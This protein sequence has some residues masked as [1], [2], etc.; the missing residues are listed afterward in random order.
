MEGIT[1]AELVLRPY[2]SDWPRVF[3]QVRV[4]LESEFAPTLI[5]IEHIGSTAVP[6]LSAKPVI[7]LALGASILETYEEHIEGLQQRGFNYVNKYEH[8]LPMRRYFIHSGFQ[9]F[10]IHVHGLITDGELWKQ[11]IYFRDQLRQ[12]S[13]LRLAYERLKIDLAQKHLH[14]K[15]KY[16]EAKAPFIQSVL[17]TMPKSPLSSLKSLGPKSQEML[18]AAG[19]HHL[20]DLQRLGSVA[21]YAQVKQ[22]C[23]KASLNLLWALESALTGMPWQEVSRQ[24]RTTLLLALEDLAR[25][26]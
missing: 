12:S 3:E 20:D 23:P 2:S 7:D 18:E 25:R 11:H 1:M 4:E 16:T 24:H 15:E 26:N 6:G 21:A 5:R 19:I 10:R 22:V 8:I 13:E 9:G 17:A 14:E